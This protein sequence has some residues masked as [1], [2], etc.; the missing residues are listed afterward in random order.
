VAVTALDGVY[1]F[2]PETLKVKVGAQV[3]WQNA[4]E[5]PHDV[6]SDTRG[7]SF[8][9]SLGLHGVVRVRF[10]RPGTYRYHCSIHPGMAGKIVVH[11]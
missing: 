2:T 10:T 5:V 1:R 6:T 9:K 11:R 7:W 3:V 4:S 8:R